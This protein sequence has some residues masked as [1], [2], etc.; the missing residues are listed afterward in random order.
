MRSLVAIAALAG[1]VFAF[2]AQANPSYDCAKALSVA[3][4]EICRVPDLQWF[5]R[6]LARL[7]NLAK[8][9]AGANRERIVVQQRQFI[10][11]REACRADYDCLQGAYK[12]R[13]AEL[14]TQVNVFEAYAEYSTK[15]SSSTMWIVRD[16]YHAG[17]KILTVGGGGHT[18]VFEADNATTTGKGV[19]KW[20]GTAGDAC[21]IDIIPDA[22]AL[23]VETHDC[24]DYCGMRA[25]MDGVYSHAR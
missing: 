6:Q 13:L 20:R 21:R 4:K 3:E 11:R 19:V 25:Q 17:V 14:A 9:Q 12:A 7:F 5:D 2:S 24:Q 18:C 22:D 8:E 15:T 16:G 23:R 1:C 10:V